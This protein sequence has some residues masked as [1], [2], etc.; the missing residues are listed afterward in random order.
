MRFEDIPQFTKFSGYSVDQSW[1]YLPRHY[2]SEV[3]N[4]GLDVNP[5]FQR[6]YVWTLEQKTRYVE[7]ILKGGLSSRER[8]NKIQ[9]ILNETKP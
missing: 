7:Y 2:A 3:L 4:Y 6:G 1:V 8:F 5:D 9:Q